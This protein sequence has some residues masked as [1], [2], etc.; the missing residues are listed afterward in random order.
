MPRVLLFVNT[1]NTTDLKSSFFPKLYENCFQFANVNYLTIAVLP[2]ITDAM[3]LDDILGL[4]YSKAREIL[5]SSGNFEIKVD[6]LFNKPKDFYT[7]QTWDCVFIP[8]DLEHSFKEKFLRVE[9][10]SF[11]GTEQ[12]ETFSKD[13]PKYTEN[14]YKVSALG[15]TFDHIHDGHKILLSVAAFLTSKKLI[16]G[17]THDKLLVNKKYKEFLQPIEVR[18]SNVKNFLNLIK[19]GLKIELVR[20]KDVCGPTGTAPDIE[21]LVVSR[22]TVKGGETVNNTRQAHGLC[23][24]KIFVVNVL[25]GREEDGWKEKVSSTHLRELEQ[26]KQDHCNKILH[27]K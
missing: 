21:A 4:I 25:G 20:I 2:R 5:L 24:L 10:Y 1:V 12:I 22:E 17:I 14:F 8:K 19:P 27:P 11:S 15:G 7:T 9:F 26:L 6:V 18:E 16:I 23:P 3:H 13:E